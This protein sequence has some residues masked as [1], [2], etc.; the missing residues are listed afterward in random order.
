M[1][2]H[3]LSVNILT[4]NRERKEGMFQTIIGTISSFMY[5]KLLVILLIGAGVYFTIRTRFPQVRLLKNA[6]GSVMEKPEDRGAISSFQA[7]MVSTASRVGTG[8]IVGVSSAICIGGF[9]SVFWMWV[10]AIIG[11]ASA[12][13]ESTLAQIYKKKGED[14]SCYGGPAYYIE[15]AL[16]CRPLAIVFC[17]AMILTYAFGFNMLASYNLQSTFSVFSFYEAKMSPWIIGGILA[18]LTGWCLLGGGSRIVKVTS[19]VV[20]VMGIAYIG[21]SLLVVIINIQNVPAMFVRIFEEAFDFKAIFGA[22]SGSAMM[23]GIRRG[24]YSNEAGIG[25]APNASASANVSHPVKQG[26]IQALGVFIDTLVICSCSAFLMLLAPAEKIE[27]LMGMDLLQAAMNHHL[28]YAGVVFIAV[29]LFLFSFSTFLGILYYA[30]CN[31]SYVFG[32]TWTAQT[33][34]KIFLLIMLFIGGVAA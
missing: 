25:S 18:V 4:T 11:S 24:L 3:L 5:S 20:P 6:C 31:V 26:L 30:R 9:G 27:G 19:M 33:G 7:L 2:I 16:H 17:V 32:D 15:A 28:G 10:I 1:Q 8:N 21:I 29:V 13:I 14:G 12:L 22:F 34:Y 23:Q